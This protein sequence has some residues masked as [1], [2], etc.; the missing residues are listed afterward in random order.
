MGS[1]RAPVGLHVELT[2]FVGRRAAGLL[3]LD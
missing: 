2:E 1:G 3:V